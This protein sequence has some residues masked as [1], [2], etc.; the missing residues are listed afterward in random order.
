MYLRTYNVS[1]FTASQLVPTYNVI[2]ICIILSDKYVSLMVFILLNN[3]TQIKTRDQ[4]FVPTC[5][6]NSPMFV[7]SKYE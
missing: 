4:V 2:G 7:V 5:A 3:L 6:S 1:A